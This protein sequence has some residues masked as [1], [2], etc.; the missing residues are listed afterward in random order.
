M[1]AGFLVLGLVAALGSSAM[2]LILGYSLWIVLLSYMLGGMLG[3]S[4]GLIW[5]FLCA[6]IRG[7]PGLGL[8]HRHRHGQ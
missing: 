5:G 4:L 8:Y 1:V 3:V 2:A 6:R 7:L